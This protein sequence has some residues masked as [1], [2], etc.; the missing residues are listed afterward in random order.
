MPLWQIMLWSGLVASGVALLAGVLH[1]LHR[2]GLWLEKRGLLYYRDRKP[3]RS[4]AGCLIELQKHL[5][6]STKHV[7][8]LRQEKR[9]HCEREV[10][11]QKG[12]A[13]RLR[14]ASIMPRDL[15]C[16]HL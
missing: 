16:G 5:E 11:G 9:Q 4:A 1:G 8:E 10:P 6:P 7:I 14:V 13:S 15:R 2:L 3:E 12:R